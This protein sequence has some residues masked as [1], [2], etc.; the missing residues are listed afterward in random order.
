MVLSKQQTDIVM[1]DAKNIIVDAAAGSGKTRVLVERVRRLLN[2]GADP[3]SFVVITFTNEAANELKSRL[4]DICNSDKCFIGTIH[5]Y[6]HKLLK[7][8]GFDFEIF[9]EYYQTEYMNYLIKKYAL[10]CT[11]DDYLD[12][13][14]YDKL[15]VSGKISRSSIQSKFSDTKIYSELMQLLGRVPSSYYKETVLTLCKANNVISFDELIELSTKYFS[16]SDTSVGYLFVD[17]LQDIGYLEYSFL[18]SLNAENN[19]VIGDDYQA[20]FGFK[21]GDVNI[22]LSLMENKDW[23]SFTLSENYRTAKSILNYANSII[24]KADNI[25]S[26][27][28]ICKNSNVGELSFIAKS[29][30]D[31]FLSKLNADEQ[32]FILA[33]SNRE[34]NMISTALSKMNK[35]HY[36]FKRSVSNSSTYDAVKNKNCIVVMTIH[37]AKGLES[38]R[39]AIYGKFK[40]DA[41]DMDSDEIKVYYV[42]LTRAKNKCVVFV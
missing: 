14:K 27:D 8:S 2:N 1:S 3:S 6:A 33:R 13:L 35:N 18:M 21:G 12:F 34:M 28:V 9:S 11:F 5:S 36:C 30:L 17:E 25:I 10:Y 29:Q 42:A 22:F 15:A 32:W 7:K 40:A 38:E 39:V 4:S 26:K 23:T 20:I 41:K 37:A 31:K 19:F 24:K 16:E